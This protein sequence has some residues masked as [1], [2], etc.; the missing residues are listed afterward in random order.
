MFLDLL[1]WGFAEKNGS[2]GELNTKK[3]WLNKWSV[4][5]FTHWCFISQR[6]HIWFILEF[7]NSTSESDFWKINFLQMTNVSAVSAQQA[8]TLWFQTM[9]HGVLTGRLSQHCYIGSVCS[10]WK[11]FEGNKSC[12]PQPVGVS[13]CPASLNV[14]RTCHMSMHDE[15][16]ASEWVTPGNPCCELSNL[17]CMEDKLY[18]KSTDV[19]LLG[20]SQKVR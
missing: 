5:V 20:C 14:S 15:K 12:F 7:G 17:E 11:R 9:W 19:H 6:K 3:Q 18:C 10:Q 16:Q 1:C 13:P 8:S 2:G 4:S